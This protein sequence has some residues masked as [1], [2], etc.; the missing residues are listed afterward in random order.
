MADLAAALVM[1]IALLGL[2]YWY[3]RSNNGDRA[4]PRAAH[5]PSQGGSGAHALAEAEADFE[6][7]TS[8]SGSIS[9]HDGLR[10]PAGESAHANITGGAG[11]SERISGADWRRPNG[12]PRRED[13]DG[14]DDDDDL[15]LITL[16][17]PEVLQTPIKRPS[18]P[19]YGGEEEDEDDE[20]HEREEPSAVPII[21]D[22][23]AAIDEPTSSSP[24][25]LISA[26]GQTDPGQKRKKNED[27]YLCLDEHYLFAVADG[28][29]GHAGGDVAS[30]LAVDTIARAFKDQS[31][32]DG[33]GASPYPDVPRRGSELAVA[34]QRANQAIYERAHADRSLS[35]M[36]TTLVSARFSP[37]KQRLYIG[38]VGDSRCYRLRDN[39][40]TQLT[41]DHTMGAAGITGPMANHLSRAI[42]IS[43]AVKVDLIIA[44]PHPGDVYLLCSDGL[45]K[46][47]THEAIRDILLSEPD[48]E[49]ASQALIEKANASGGRDNITV[50]L[51][52]VSDPKDLARLASRAG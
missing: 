44:R 27:C 20:D 31:F 33:D 16:A 50:I 36:G 25:L 24:L 2:I 41:T 38:H 32:V 51:V 21:Y 49:K 40:L 17:P 15:T 18:A 4:R 30:R 34:I 6:S 12:A 14:F 26:V 39:E 43:P 5:A 35:G 48:P 13:D 47:A 37:N 29:G 11:R 3:F 28:M 23:E 8:G 45:S 10:A 9:P 1:G 22:D 19:S 42:G 52:R 46:M 7:S